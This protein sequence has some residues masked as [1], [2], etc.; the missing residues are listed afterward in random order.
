MKQLVL[1]VVC[2]LSTPTKFAKPNDSGIKMV[3]KC[4]QIVRNDVDFCFLTLDV[5]AHH[6]C[7]NHAIMI[8]YALQNSELIVCALIRNP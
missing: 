4:N 5:D 8:H 6:K 7:Y 2:R 1:P 3:C